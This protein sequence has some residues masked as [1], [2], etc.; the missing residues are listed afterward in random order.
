M[1]HDIFW[2]QVNRKPGEFK[3]QV[4]MGNA[5]LTFSSVIGTR[6]S[7]ASYGNQLTILGFLAYYQLENPFVDAGFAVLV[8]EPVLL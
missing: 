1:K 3:S 8:P 4:D 2:I 5:G 7:L 6:I